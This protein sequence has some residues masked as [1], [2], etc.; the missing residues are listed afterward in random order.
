MGGRER[1]VFSPNL[2]ARSGFAAFGLA[3]ARRS[4]AFRIE[5]W[6]HWIGSAMIDI[7]EAIRVGGIAD[8]GTDRRCLFD[9]AGAGGG[10]AALAHRQSATGGLR[11]AG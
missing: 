6:I 3:W 10:F 11:H 5:A 9:V 4:F 2:A 7:D 8:N 1:A